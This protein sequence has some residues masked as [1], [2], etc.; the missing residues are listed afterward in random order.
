MR[1]REEEVKRGGGEDGEG[2]EDG[3]RKGGEG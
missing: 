3:E 1:K 2:Y